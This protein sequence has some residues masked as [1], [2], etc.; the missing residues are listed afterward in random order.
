MVD[1][2]STVGL[3]ILATLEKRLQQSTRDRDTWKLRP[4]GE[5]RPFGGRNVILTGDLW[6]F[7]PV[8]ATAIYQNP[9]QSN[10]SFQVNALQQLCWSHTPLAIP[11][12]FELTLEQRCEDAWLSQI[13]QPARHGNM[14][15][16]V[17]GLSYMGFQHSMQG[18]GPFKAMKP[19]AAT[20]LATTY[21]FNPPPPTSGNV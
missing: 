17:C 13:L 15:Q 9:F 4:W 11:H 16:E 20:K 7:P 2:S 1:E 19:P 5:R 21:I 8:K 12:L 14:S 18:R 3:E 10:T 6:Q